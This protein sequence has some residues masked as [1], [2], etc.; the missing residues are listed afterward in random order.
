M[1]IIIALMLS[2]CTKVFCF[3]LF[4]YTKQIF[5]A[6]IFNNLNNYVTLYSFQNVMG[7][8]AIQHK[9]IFLKY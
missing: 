1:H 8:P 4:N 5:I 7:H 9:C 6:L 3:W 2:Y